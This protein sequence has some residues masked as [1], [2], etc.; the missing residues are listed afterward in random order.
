MG[1]VKEDVEITVGEDR[2]AECRE[3]KFLDVWFDNRLNL[4]KTSAVY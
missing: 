1:L 3:T 4:K 2:V